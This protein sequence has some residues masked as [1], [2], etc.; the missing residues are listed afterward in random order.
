MNFNVRI[1]K[2]NP[3]LSAPKV[4]KEASEANLRAQIVLRRL[5][6]AGLNACRPAKKSFI[7]KK[8]K[9]KRLKFAC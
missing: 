2:K 1:S 5:V 7:F 8:N 9:T 4:F 6:E 3:N